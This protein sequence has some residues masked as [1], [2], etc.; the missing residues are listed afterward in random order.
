MMKI[1]KFNKSYKECYYC[2]AANEYD[3]SIFIQKI[4]KQICAAEDS[5]AYN[6][7]IRIFSQMFQ[8]ADDLRKIYNEYYKLEYDNFELYLYQKE[9]FDEEM[10]SMLYIDEK[11]TV[12]RLNPDLI[13]YNASTLFDYDDN[14]ME[15]INE[16]LGAIYK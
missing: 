6:Y 9:I 3:F 11:H 12:L 10:L 5:F 13:S 2:I 7:S 1:I 15:L 14:N 16:I 8:Y 4:K